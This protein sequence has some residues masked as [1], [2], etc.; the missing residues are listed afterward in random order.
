MILVGDVEKGQPHCGE[1]PVPP[2]LPLSF[3]REGTALVSPQI[4][5]GNPTFTLRLSPNLHLTSVF[6]EAAPPGA[7]G[8]RGVTFCLNGRPSSEEPNDPPGLNRPTVPSDLFSSEV[9]DDQPGLNTGPPDLTLDSVVLPVTES[10]ELRCEE[11]EL[12]DALPTQY[13]ELLIT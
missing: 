3:P 12:T 10:R 1:A 5:H 8:S 11:G 13:S 2:P 4:S 7:G 6:H 9:N